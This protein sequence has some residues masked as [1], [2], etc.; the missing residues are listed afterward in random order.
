MKNQPTTRHLLQIRRSSHNKKG[1]P[2][3]IRKQEEKVYTGFPLVPETE[4]DG[5]IYGA[6][7]DFLEADSSKEGCTNG[8]GFVQAPDGSRAGL[9]WETKSKPYTEI[10]PPDE[11]RWGVYDVRFQKP[12]KSLE[13]LIY[14]FRHVLPYLIERYYLGKYK[15]LNNILNEWDF[16]G[17][18]EAAVVD[19]YADIL[20]PIINGLV[21]G[22][23]QKDLTELIINFVSKHYGDKPNRTDEVSKEILKWWNKNHK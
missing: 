23:N 19:E 13:D 6:I 14:N 20:Q 18:V 16:L 4:T 8:D 12:I 11:T 3:F 7:T 17:V 2:F 5:W 15:E 1:E 21:K 10:S 9:V 22:V